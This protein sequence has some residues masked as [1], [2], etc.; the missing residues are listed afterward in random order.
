MAFTPDFLDQLKNRSSISAVVGRRVR[1]TRRGREHVGLCP[2]HKEKTPS[3]TVS[4]DK[5]FFH[6]FGCGAN[7]SVFDFVMQTEGLSFPEAVERLAA[8]AGMEVP[9]ASPEARTA[10]RERDRLGDALNRTCEYFEK[11]LRMPEGKVGLDYLVGRGLDDATI[12]TFRLGYAPPQRGAL[13]A[14]LAR[15]DVTEKDMVEAG[16][17]KAGDNGGPIYEYMRGRVTFPITDRRGRIIGF[18]GRIIGEGE[19]KYLNTPETALFHKG[20]NLYGLHL[21]LAEARS[22]N[23]IIV[24]EGYMDVIALHRAGFANAVAPLGTALTEEQIGELW[25]V[26]PEPI[27]CFDGDAAGQRAASRAAER[28]LPLLKPGFGLRFAMLPSREDPDSFVRRRGRRAM[29][30]ILDAAE[31]LSEMLWQRESAG[32]LP[33]TPE[34]RAK[35]QGRLTDLA[36][37][38]TDPTVKSHFRNNFRERV[39][40]RKK[41]STSAAVRPDVTPASQAALADRRNRHAEQTL[42]AIVLNHPELFETVGEILGSLAFSDPGRDRFRQELVS[43]FSASSP[44]TIEALA[45]EL[46]RGK[47]AKAAQALLADPLIRFNRS[48]APEASREDALAVWEDNL[49]FLRKV[50]LEA[51]FER[52][53]KA[54]NQPFSEADWRRDQQL[55]NTVNDA[56]PD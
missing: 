13:T 48:V 22:S 17:A 8:E 40:A 35:L 11:S 32:R 16:I 39:W 5:A 10:A 44:D 28:A 36:D 20:R 46:E 30:E 1:L 26:A 12:A 56:K 43:I 29:S 19:P 21:A 7:G 42:L 38:I 51:E 54:G 55:L 31:P 23:R 27:L 47:L 33:A 34:A 37:R 24:T 25:R 3:F 18:G 50:G 2:F 9:V 41:G 45:P 49:E 53:G 14:A 15:A 4:D 52:I 6:C